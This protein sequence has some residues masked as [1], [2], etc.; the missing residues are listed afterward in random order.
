MTVS[1][2]IGILILSFIGERILQP[3]QILEDKHKSTI[4]L[5]LHIV[6]WCLP[7]LA[8]S[9]VICYRNHNLNALLW[10]STNFIF[11]FT[12]DYLVN[13]FANHHWNK[14][15]NSTYTTLTHLDVLLTT[16]ALIISYKIIV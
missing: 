5:I 4:A 16:L 2:I 1:N 6:Y 12:I 9:I 8:F 14:R 15:S 11:H 7:L 10:L 3:K 13:W